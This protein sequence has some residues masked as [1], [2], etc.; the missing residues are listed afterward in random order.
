MLELGRWSAPATLGP[1]G[2]GSRDD[3]Y[4]PTHTSSSF[5][6]QSGGLNR[7]IFALL[8]KLNQQGLGRLF[9]V[10]NQ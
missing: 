9:P 1:L 6:S 3:G 4:T 7:L 10:S 8:L 2:T 5:G